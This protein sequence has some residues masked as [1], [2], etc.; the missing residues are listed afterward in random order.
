MLLAK[1]SF[2]SSENTPNI[3]LMD[4]QSDQKVAVANTLDNVIDNI[5]IVT[6]RVH[7][8]K[9]R[10]ANDIRKDTNSTL[11]QWVLNHEFRVT[12]RD[13]LVESESLISGTWVA[14]ENYDGTQPISISI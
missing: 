8:I 1:L 10:L 13:S 12:Y 11:N 6:M 14:E 7:S 5:P 9:G 2:E 4:V 3:I